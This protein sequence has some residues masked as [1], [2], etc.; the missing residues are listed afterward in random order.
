MEQGHYYISAWL[1]NVSMS[2]QQRVEVSVTKTVNSLRADV[3]WLCH[4]QISTLS[5]SAVSY[6][7]ICVTGEGEA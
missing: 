4:L 7:L 5:Q 1:L 3:T 2:H 6:F